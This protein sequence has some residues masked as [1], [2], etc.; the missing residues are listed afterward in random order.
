MV[1]HAFIP[2]AE[3]KKQQQQQQQ[4]ECGAVWYLF[5]VRPHY[6]ITCAHISR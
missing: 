2:V 3:Q 5:T 6:I 1:Y 4:P